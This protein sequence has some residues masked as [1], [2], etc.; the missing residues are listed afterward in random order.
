MNEAELALWTD[1][2]QGIEAACK[3]L[4]LSYF[5]LVKKWARRISRIANWANQEDLIQDGVIGLINAIKKFDPHR[6]VAFE[7]YASPYVRGA[8]FDSSELTRD[9]AR[10]QEE[11]CRKIK[12][13]D[14]ELTRTLERNPTVDE[15]AH[16]TGL[17][18]D[19]IMNAIDAMGVAFARELND[20]NEPSSTG[21]VQPARQERAAV[22]QDALARLSEREQ[23]VI[24]FYYWQGQSHEEIARQLGLTV[25]NSSQIRKRA[26]R[27]LRK[28]LRAEET[29]E[30]DEDRRSGK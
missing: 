14:I 21:G 28:L 26:I 24:D 9:L 10:R 29:G 12:R 8:I 23:S 15:V 16:N 3:E 20:A 13:A 2:G 25:S 18:V 30:R 1:C 19:Q 11:I 5:Y 6:G 17:S 4:I 27:K 22:I 7:R